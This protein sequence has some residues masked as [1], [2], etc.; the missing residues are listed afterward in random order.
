MKKKKANNNTV[1]LPLEG[2]RFVCP[3]PGRIELE[4]FTTDVLPEDGVLIENAYTAVSAGT[5]IFGFLHGARPGVQPVYP[6]YT[7]YCN[8]GTVLAVGPSVTGVAPGDRVAGIGRHAGHVVLT[9]QYHRVPEGV[10]LKGASLLVMAAVA[11]NGIRK[12]R[13]ELGTSVVV[14]GL[15]LVGQL[16]VSL[17]RLAGAYPIIAVDLDGFRL[18]KAGHRGADHLLNPG[19]TA[20]FVESVRALCPEDGANVV[21]EATG[22]PRVYP[23]AV[24]LACRAGRLVALGSPRGTVEMNFLDDVHLREV[25]IIGAFQPFTPD[26]DH[27]YYPWTKSRERG[28]LLDLMAAGRLP[29]A[30]LITHVAQPEE[31]QEIYTMLADNP[32]N[33]LGVLFDWT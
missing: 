9:D 16:A 8:A 11:L 5:E 21:I 19:E 29:V 31:C 7:G 13:L 28:L 22:L 10:P 15:G 20:D 32:R 18:E 14:L 6:R 24:K 27:I 26:D 3:G 23:T 12:A 33:A 17:A 4:T 25:A 30:D 1:V 2:Q